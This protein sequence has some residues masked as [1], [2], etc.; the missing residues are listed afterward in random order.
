M[1][2]SWGFLQFFALL[3]GLC[4]GSF[5][6]VCVA[7]M[8]EDRSII[9]P[10]S[11]CPHCGASI[12]WYDNIPVVSWMVLRAR[13]R[14][15]SH[16]IS[17]VYPLVELTTG[18][19]VLLLWRRLVPDPQ[20]VDVAHLA[21]FGWYTIFITALLGLTFVDLE[22]YIIPDEFSIY[23]VP[24]GVLGAA[25]IHALE[26]TAPVPTWQQSVMGAAI[27]GGA[28]LLL[29]G[30]Y[31]LVRREEGIGM[32]DVK[33]LAMVGSFLGAFPALFVVVLLGSITGSVVGV[34]TMIARRGGLRSALPFGPFLALGALV[35]L[36]FGPVL[37]GRVL[38]GIPYLLG[39]G[40]P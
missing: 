12:R 2:V 15:C 20:A 16:P 14:A 28:L 21:A 24:L 31:Y 4:L 1:T 26:P 17:A 32:G 11:H 7:R 9:R 27:G 13:C 19:A 23:A 36:Y 10:A 25:G 37:L 8:P 35:Q 6:N 34:G 3:L 18:L 30:V 39:P 38:V 33:L 40:G 22:H 5:L 29:A